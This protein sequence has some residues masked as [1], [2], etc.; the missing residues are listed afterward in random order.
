M[1][2]NTY[3]ETQHNSELYVI[4]SARVWQNR[5]PSPPVLISKEKD[6][7]IS[8]EEVNLKPVW[9]RPLVTRRP[10]YGTPFVTSSKKRG[11]WN[12]CRIKRYVQFIVTI[13]QNKASCTF[14]RN[15][16]HLMVT[17]KMQFKAFLDIVAKVDVSLLFGPLCCRRFPSLNARMTR[18][19]RVLIGQ[20]NRVRY[21]TGRCVCHSKPKATTCC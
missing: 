15:I 8:W 2:Y 10:R 11:H 17:L 6:E 3:N 19:R 1:A 20:C 9:G 12:C 13:V 14:T 5:R 21:L 18:L 16:L 7:R 4:P